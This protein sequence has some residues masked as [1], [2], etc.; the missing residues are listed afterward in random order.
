MKTIIVGLGNPLLTDDSVGIK[1][2]RTLAERF[3]AETSIDVT[4]VYA[5]GLRLM[6][7]L[8]GYDRAIIID[9][10]VTA[11]HEPGTIKQFSLSEML[12][13]RNSMGLHDMDLTM[14]LELGNMADLVLPKD[15]K[16]YGVE[17]MDIV[18]FSEELT[19]KVAKA[20]SEVIKLVE[21]ELY[22]LKGG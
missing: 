1:V 21:E 10:M 11:Q 14:A 9:A 17:A 3:A 8:V 16:F 12:N 5:G 2:S 15:I 20:L 18:S 7:V 13:T 6:D 4:E 22:E 19:P